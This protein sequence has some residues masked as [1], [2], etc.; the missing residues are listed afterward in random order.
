V[1]EDSISKLLDWGSRFG[2]GDAPRNEDRTQALVIALAFSISMALTELLHR[3][4][5]GRLPDS[6]LR[7]AA[8]VA[9]TACAL[10][11]LFGLLWIP[12]AASR[13]AFGAPRPA[14]GTFSV[15]IL[16]A[17]AGILYWLRPEIGGEPGLLVLVSALLLGTAV[18]AYQL[19]VRLEA[20][21]LA[22][23]VLTALTAGLPFALLIAVLG[24]SAQAYPSLES[25][26]PSHCSAG[27]GTRLGSG[28]CSLSC[29]WS[30]PFPC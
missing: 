17:P 8:P 21:A 26:P 23:R 18:A 12:L 20:S 9:V 15:A 24:V 3:L 19:L 2:L 13:R 4:L 25:S 7:Y 30:Y 11:L 16:L 28:A 10:L 6:L 14:A 29:S 22:S 27:S 5:F 1:P